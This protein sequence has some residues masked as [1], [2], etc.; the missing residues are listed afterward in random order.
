MSR[1]VSAVNQPFVKVVATAS[2]RVNAMSGPLKQHIDRSNASGEDV[3]AAVWNEYITWQQELLS[4]RYGKFWAELREIS[5]GKVASF[6]N[7]TYKECII[8]LRVVTKCICLFLICTMVGRGTV[9]P[10]LEPT[11]PFM[12]EVDL[13]QPNHR[14]HL[15]VNL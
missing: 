9:Y 4:Y 14:R 11:S 10:L 13:L 7:T 8:G 6:A 15:N 5:S 3:T 2:A 1:L 12:Q